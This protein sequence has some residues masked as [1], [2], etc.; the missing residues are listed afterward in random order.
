MGYPN[1]FGRGYLTGFTSITTTGNVTIGGRTT[2]AGLSLSIDGDATTPA[3]NRTT[4]TNTGFYWDSGGDNLRA[5]ANGGAVHAFSAAFSTALGNFLTTNGASITG[6]NLSLEATRNIAMAG[7]YIDMTEIAAPSAPAA[8][9]GRIYVLDAA[10]KTRLASLFPSG[11]Q[12]NITTE[13]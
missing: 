9:V 13:P 5:I 3:I 1:Q 10:T 4:D 2:T 11:V 6:G 7:G 12:Q 8:N